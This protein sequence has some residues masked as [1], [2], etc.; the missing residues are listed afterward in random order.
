L[1]TS[2]LNTVCGY[3]P[4]GILPYN[5]LLFSDTR[6]ELVETAM[7]VLIITLDHDSSSS[8]PLLL[9]DADDRSVSSL[10]HGKT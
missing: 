2:L 9:S 8:P 5:H 1:F 3:D 7:Q 4:A 6:E 10:T